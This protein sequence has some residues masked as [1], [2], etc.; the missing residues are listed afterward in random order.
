MNFFC[1]MTSDRRLR[2]NVGD[3]DV[4]NHSL[5]VPGVLAVQNLFMSSDSK[6]GE[7]HLPRPQVSGLL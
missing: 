4:K 3:Q 1:F 2:P 6:T 5:G 7:A